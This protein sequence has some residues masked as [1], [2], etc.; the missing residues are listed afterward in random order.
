[1]KNQKQSQKYQKKI[2][3]LKK[4]NKLLLIKSKK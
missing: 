3:Q 2:Y 4:K 1:M